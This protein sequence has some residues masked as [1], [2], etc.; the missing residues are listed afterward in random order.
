[1]THESTHSPRVVVLRN[2][3]YCFLGAIRGLAEAGARVLSVVWDWEGSGPWISAESKHF[4]EVEAIPN[5][6]EDEAA[7]AAAFL[8][9]GK[10]LAA[11]E[12]ELPMVIASSDTGLM[13]LQNHWDLFGSTFRMMGHTEFQDSRYDCLDKGQCLEQLKA[14][15]CA[16]PMTMSV[17]SRADVVS[18]TQ[19]MVYPCV[20]KPAVKDYGQT[21]YR[22]HNMLKAIECPDAETLEAALYKEVDAG[23]ELVV[24]EKILFDSAYDEIPFYLYADEHHQIRLAT[25]AIK[26]SIRPFPFGTATVLRLDWEAELL[27]HA[28]KVVKALKWRGLLMIEFIRDKKDRRWKVVEIN[29]RPW[30]FNDFFRQSG[31]DYLGY[32]VDDIR[33]E[34]DKRPTFVCPESTEWARQHVHIDL[35]AELAGLREELGSAPA[36]DELLSRCLAAVEGRVSFAYNDPR[37]RGPGRKRLKQVKEVY[38]LNDAVGRST[39]E[40]SSQRP[41]MPGTV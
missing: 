17:R 13:F 16:I 1:V 41:A 35:L 39:L 22:T 29:V 9:L 23:F 20:Y 32:L 14:D 15:D 36:D 6:Y 24:Q 2:N 34:L 37:D 18:V 11:E 25:T 33:G 40:S 12:N 31:F 4:Q 5:P 38:A 7:A 27:P 8:A 19:N 10:R 3:D 30:L 21:F 26:D 28:Q